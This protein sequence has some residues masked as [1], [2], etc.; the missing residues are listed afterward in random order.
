MRSDAV[1]D[2]A[3]TTAPMAHNAWIFMMGTPREGKGTAGK[4]FRPDTM[5]AVHGNAP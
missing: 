4:G 5:N 3:A 2:E 1:A